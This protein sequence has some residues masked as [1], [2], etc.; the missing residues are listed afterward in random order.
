MIYYQQAVKNVE[1]NSIRPVY[2]LFGEEQYLA[3]ELI[4]RL[5]EKF[6]EKPEAELNYFVRY[7][8]DNRVDDVLSLTSGM[9]L[10]AEKKFILLKE[11]DQL[12]QKDIER[13]TPYLEH[14]AKDICLLMQASISSLYKTR[15][16]K[17]ED[18]VE[19]VNLMPLRAEDLKKF[20]IRE[21]EKYSRRIEPAAIDVLIF[22]VGN[23]LTDLTSQ[24]YN[25]S[26]YY[27]NGTP[28][29]AEEVEEIA[30]IYATQDVFELSRLIGNRDRQK[31]FWVMNKLLES[32]VSPQQILF[33]LIRHFT[34]LF[35]MHG[36]MR[37]GISRS[38]RLARELNIYPKYLEE[39]REQISLWKFSRLKNI[40][41]N[42]LEADRELKNSALEPQIVLDMLSHKIL[43]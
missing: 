40:F 22:M 21:F 5:R 39:Y 14:P 23:Q 26:H 8:S 10:F 41:Q 4:K 2:L 7:A 25:I 32:G 36:F 43:N 28:V 34:I 33:Q 35:R 24:I 38:D 18:L 37:I 3:D 6:L 19:A 42:L 17:I 11:A 30:G 20:I 29:S 9:G 12:K 1:E 31:A 13:L 27:G 16:K 15:L